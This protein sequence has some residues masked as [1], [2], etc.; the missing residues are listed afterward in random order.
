MNADRLLA[1]ASGCRKFMRGRIFD[2]A[3]F[4]ETI[5]RYIDI[6]GLS[7]RSLLDFFQDRSGTGIGLQ[8]LDRKQYPLLKKI[9]ICTC[10]QLASIMRNLT[11]I[12]RP[13]RSVSI[14]R[15]P[16]DKLAGRLPSGLS[17]RSNEFRL[18]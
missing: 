4:S 7:T 11:R 15:Q 1:D 16:L 10:H 5:K 9:N 14:R 18:R 12:R 8:P 3:F 13:R 17:Y 2:D 6:A